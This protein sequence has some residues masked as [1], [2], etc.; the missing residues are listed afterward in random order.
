MTSLN[1]WYEWLD[2]KFECNHRTKYYFKASEDAM[3]VLLV[4]K[5]WTDEPCYAWMTYKMKDKSDPGTITITEELTLPEGK[6]IE[7]HI[8]TLA[9]ILRG[10][11]YPLRQ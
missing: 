9:G 3:G 5:A 10:R 4:L 11:N 2:K 6:W 7:Y 1:P 8:F